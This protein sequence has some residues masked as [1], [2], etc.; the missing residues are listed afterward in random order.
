M[1]RYINGDINRKLWFAV[2]SSDA[3]DQFG[4]TGEQ[5]NEL[6]YYFDE[7][8]LQEVNE[9]IEILENELGDWKQKLDEFFNKVNGYNKQIVEEHGLDYYMFEKMI[10]HYADLEL[11]LDIK[12]CIEENGSCEFTAEI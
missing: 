1:G 8:N 3:A 5:P 6:Y 4:V 12:K 2:Q 11:G 7:S 9:Q 10:K